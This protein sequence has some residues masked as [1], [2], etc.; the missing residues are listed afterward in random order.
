[1]KNIISEIKNNINFIFI[2]RPEKLNSLDSQ[3]IKELGGVI[4]EGVK[5]K[6]VRCFII[7]GS[8]N[9][10]FVAG[11]DI[12]EFARYSKINGEKLSIRGHRELFDL[13]ENSGTPSIAAINGFALGGGLELAMCCHIRV[14]SENAKLGLPEVSLGVIPGY[15]GTQRLPQLVGKGRALEMISTGKMISSEEALNYGLVNHVCRQ[16]ELLAFSESL[17]KKIVKNSPNAISRAIK[18]VNMGFKSG[19]NGYIHEQKEFGN[20]FE[21]NDFTEGVSAFLEKRNPKF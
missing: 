6:E 8:G 11:A 5:N 18:A 9:K 17:A 7:S 13:I 14:C 2:N 3:T 10:A 15:G 21:T 20:C 1:M 12:K 4:K 19:E 16:E